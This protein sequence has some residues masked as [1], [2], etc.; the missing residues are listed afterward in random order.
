M[1]LETLRASPLTLLILSVVANVTCSVLWHG[2]PAAD[3]L[4]GHP[5]P[6][7]PIP[8]H[9]Q[10]IPELAFS[11]S[12]NANCALSFGPVLSSGGLGTVGPVPSP[13]AVRFLNELNFGVL[14]GEMVPAGAGGH[15]G[16]LPFPSSLPPCPHLSLA[17][18]QQPGIGPSV[19]GPAPWHGCCPLGRA[20]VQS[21]HCQGGRAQPKALGLPEIAL[22]TE[23]FIPFALNEVS[24]LGKMLPAQSWLHPS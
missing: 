5:G 15:G 19:K 17:P 10:P 13:K 2:G 11:Q 18:R 14:S 12:P 4:S 9:G 23:S 3:Y 8:W 7:A 21:R 20:F 16:T 1:A 24:W 22:D 6:S